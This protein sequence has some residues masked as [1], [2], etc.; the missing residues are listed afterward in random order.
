M[1]QAAGEGDVAGAEGADALAV[2]VGRGD[3]GAEDDAGHDGG[4]GG[5]VVTLHVG[6][7]VGLG[8][9]QGLRLGEG[10]AVGGP[11]GGHAAEYVVGGAVDDAHDPAH[12]LA[13]QG[14]PQRPHERDGPA[15]GRL[16]Q[17]VHA[18][19]AGRGEQL[20]A[21]RGDD[22]LVCGH[23]RLAAGHGRQ[24]QIP[25]GVDAADE[26]HHDV[27]VRARHHRGGVAGEQLGRHAGALT[28]RRADR[29]RD[30]LEHHAAAGGDLGPALG[31]Q[32]HQRGADR[33]ATQDPHTD[34]PGG[35][36]G[37]TRPGHGRD[38]GRVRSRSDHPAHATGATARHPA[39]P[40]GPATGR[41]GG[42]RRGFRGG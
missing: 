18:G 33:A 13:G 12:R 35:G 7:G 20:G 17:Q 37:S 24:Q 25:G 4:L 39:P 32:P 11:G 40:R 22:L 14:L 8:V 41:G 2:D 26:L 31:Q 42:G 29:H 1:A 27:G 36:R 16:E 9:A 19:G 28:L 6:A 30:G 3:L 23:D 5:G 10:V 34:P 21:V 38:T 15:D